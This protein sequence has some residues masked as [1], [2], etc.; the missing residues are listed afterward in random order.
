MNK[1]N[2]E[3]QLFKSERVSEKI[4]RIRGIA[5]ELMYL[6]EGTEEAFL[7]DTGVG[8][9]NLKKF[10]KTLTDKKVTV[11]LSHGHVDHALGAGLFENVYMN[12]YDEKVYRENSALSHRIAFF[13]TVIDHWREYVKKEDIIEEPVNQFLPL[14]ERQYFFP[15]GITIE[16]L[17]LPGHTRG[18]MVFLFP[19]E[20][21]VLFGDACNS[22][23][24]LF[25]HNSCCV[26]E[27]RRSLI[28]LQDKIHGRYDRG[29]VSHGSGEAPD[30]LLES[31]IELTEDILKGK[32][33]RVPFEFMG[34]S[35]WIARK[36]DKKLRRIDGGAANIVYSEKTW[37]SDTG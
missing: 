3:T 30:G 8:I 33:D 11:L 9:G 26:S 29:Y 22:F 2:M 6:V 20:R 4:T 16:A 32:A 24:F 35:A 28:W 37:V 15:G 5:G 31:A 12:P 14:K 19:E 13:D 17:P 36:V 7:I 25:D 23:T 1:T 18:S 10:L 21:S 34:D 27:Y